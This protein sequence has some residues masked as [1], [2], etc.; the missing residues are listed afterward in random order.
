M[1]ENQSIIRYD[2]CS[3]AL[4]WNVRRRLVQVAAPA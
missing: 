4:D 1:R 2:A 3:P